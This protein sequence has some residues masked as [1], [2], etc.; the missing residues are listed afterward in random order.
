[1]PDFRTGSTLQV[2]DALIKAD[3]MFEQLYLPGRGHSLGKP[4]EF[5]RLY[6][7]FDRKLKK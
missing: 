5:H 7:F 6:E 2:V 1:M 4:Y 3:K